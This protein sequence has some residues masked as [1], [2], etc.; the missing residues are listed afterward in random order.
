MSPLSG[1][2]ILTVE[3][4][5]AGPYGSMFL[6]DL[7]AEVVKIENARTG[8]DP[9]RYVGPHLLGKADSLYFQ[10]WHMNKKSVT[11][12]LKSEAGQRDLK[13]L[14]AGA[15]AVMNNQRGDQPAE[16]GL[17]YASLRSVNPRI[18]CLHISAYGRDNARAAWPGYDFLMQAEA[19]LM[20]M[21]G[22]ADGPP[23]RIGPSMI[24][25][26]TG[27]TGVMA[28]VSCLLR[29]SQTGEG[30]DV[31]TCLFD[32]ALH[33]L[34]YAGTWHLNAGDN[35]TRQPRS[36]HLSVVPV[37][38]FPTQDGWLFV[39]CMTDKF[40]ES[41]TGAL[42]R[43]DLNTDPRFASQAA[44]RQNRD[45]LTVILD[46]EFQRQSTAHWLEKLTGLLPVAPVYDVPHALANPFVHEQQLIRTLQ[47]PAQRNLRV[48]ANPIKVNGQRL[49]QTLGSALGAD[50]AKYLRHE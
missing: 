18:V 19:G 9:S 36:A 44:R 12:D 16:L 6:A 14:A 26:M 17:D 31:D 46:A 1:I 40:W 37:Q 39:M 3:Q 22:E 49:P 42:G 45:A 34:C 5:G 48:L 13:Q 2:R 41:L 38:T 50:N 43:S 23:S 32:V 24:D 10:A 35:P 28:L 15:D 30:C 11:L 4:F 20:S 29:A 47:H 8:G 33:Q 25:Y 21:T 7:G 27:M